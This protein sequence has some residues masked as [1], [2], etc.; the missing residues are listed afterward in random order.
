MPDGREGVKVTYAVADISKLKYQPFDAKK[1][2]GE[3]GTPI[4]FAV[5]GGTVTVSL[6]QDKPKG[7]KL[8]KP[9]IPAEQMQAQM[10]MMKPMFAGMRMAVRPMAKA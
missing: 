1:A 9:K 7:D 4:T 6:P 2:A 5:S 3:E 8:E 10:A